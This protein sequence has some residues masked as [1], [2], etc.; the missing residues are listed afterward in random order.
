MRATLE[1]RP[2][3][4]LDLTV[5]ALRRVPNNP[6]D[7][8]TDGRY[9]RAFS[10]DD[11]TAIVSVTQPRADAIEVLVS[12]A[13]SQAKRYVRTAATMLGADVDLRA[14]YRAVRP[15]PWLAELTR[16]LRGLK[17]PRYPDLWEALCYAIVFQQLSIASASSIMHRLVE[18]LS[19]AV[20]FEGVQLHPFPRPQAFVA[21]RETSLRA[22]G[23]SGAK[24]AYVRSVANDVLDGKLDARAIEALPSDEAS[25]VLQR[26]RGVG[27]WSAAVILL[28]G[29]GRLD[30][31]P[32]ADSGAARKMKML[33][34]DHAIDSHGLLA[35]L[36]DTRGMLYFH[37]LLG[38][39]RR[40]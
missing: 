7:A 18:R 34:A 3:Y 37:L 1:V 33:S 28:R 6:V 2:P 36:G 40:R 5:D 20:S 4:R 27:A 10:D 17:P 15:I 8:F 9:V 25:L 30:V 12:G 11:A 32:P 35:V 16:A 13:G 29:L 19:P 23:L 31:F 24:A 38:G 22:L 14:W 39:L 26:L 21:S